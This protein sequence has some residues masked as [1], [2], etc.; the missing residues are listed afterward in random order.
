MASGSL[1]GTVKPFTPSVIIYG[2]PPKVVTTAGRP[3]LMPSHSEI[4]VASVP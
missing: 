4:D 1:G 2:F 3:M